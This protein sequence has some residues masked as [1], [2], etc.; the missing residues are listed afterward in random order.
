VLKF[1]IRHC[2]RILSNFSA[3][4][5]YTFLE[6]LFLL[7]P[8][9]QTRTRAVSTKLI[10][11]ASYVTLLP[12]AEALQVENHSGRLRKV[13][14]SNQFGI[15]HERNLLHKP[16]HNR[17]EQITIATFTSFESE[18]PFFHNSMQMIVLSVMFVNKTIF[19]PS[20]A[21]H[22]LLRYNVV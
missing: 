2:L 1:H 17:K 7:S 18:P 6:Q 9:V 21:L 15:L 16:S 20:I 10:Q 11:V 4:F 3:D 14:P 5:A 19:E 8:S 12:T 22:C 13:S